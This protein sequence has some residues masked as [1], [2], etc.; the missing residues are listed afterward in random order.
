MTLRLLLLALLASPA[1]AHSPIFPRP[2]APILSLPAIP[3]TPASLQRRQELALGASFIAV[4]ALARRPEAPPARH[5]VLSLLRRDVGS[6]AASGGGRQLASRL[7]DL[8]DGARPSDTAAPDVLA[9]PPRFLQVE[10]RDQAFVSAAVAAA[11][12][13]PTGRRILERIDALARRRGRPVRVAVRPLKGE[14]GAYDYIRD[15]LELHAGFRSEPELAAPT[16]AH[17]LQHVLQHEAGVPAEA[18]EMELEAHLVSI[19]VMRELGIAPSPETFDAVALRQLE[20]GVEDYIRW[21]Q[22]Q[23]PAK[24][25]LI[26]SGFAALEDQLDTEASELE[27]R[28]D[29]GAGKILAA[30]LDWTLRDLQL[31]R[32]AAGRRRYRGFARRV[33]A[34]L[35]RAHRRLEQRGR[36]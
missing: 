28:L 11:R 1:R 4:P 36:Q 29:R 34:R 15:V 13:S 25:L 14:W 35:G 18:L 8:W 32:S 6:L 30:R 33:V 19:E 17:E 5:A 23:L 31:V 7:E 12:R 27:Q 22:G 16:L 2:L 10:R 21:M 24:L 3:M 9:G 26:G 20:R